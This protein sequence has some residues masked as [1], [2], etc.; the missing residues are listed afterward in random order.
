MVTL[1]GEVKHRNKIP[2]SLLEIQEAAKRE[3]KKAVNEVNEFVVKQVSPYLDAAE[4]Y[5]L[6]L[7]KPSIKTSYRNSN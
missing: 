6:K 7:R 1:D 5:L 3:V 2:V 4:N